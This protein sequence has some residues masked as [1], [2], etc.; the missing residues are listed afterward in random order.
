MDKKGNSKTSTLKK[1]RVGVSLTIFALLTFFFVDFAGLLSLKLHGIAH[2]QF[3]PAL[4]AFNIAIVVVILLITS[5]FG[6]IYCSSLCPMGALQDITHWISKH[7]L[8]RKRKVK[9]AKSNNI[10]RWSV[11]GVVALA[12]LLGF[13]LLLGL[14]DPYS[15]FG[16]ISTHLFKP[17]YLLGNNLLADIFNYFGN[18]T[19][20]HIEIGILAISSFIIA[21]ATLL[22][23]GFIAWRYGRL[24][25]N[26][27]CPVG[28]ILGAISKYSLFKISIDESKCNGCRLC[29]TKCKSSCIDAE[30][31]AID[32]SRCVDCFNCLGVCNQQ[33]LSFSLK[34]QPVRKE[35]QE[36][37]VDEGKRQFLLASLATA[38]AIPSAVAQKE[39]NAL[40]GKEVAGGRTA[41]SPPGSLSAEHLKKHCTSCHLCISKCPSQVLKPAFLEYGI[42]GMMQPLLSFKNGFCKYDCTVCLEV[43]PNSAICHLTV[44]EKH[45]TQIGRA[46]LKSGSCVAYTKGAHCGICAE[47]CPTQAIKMVS[48]D[49]GFSVPVI[50]TEHCIGCGACE[51]KCPLHAIYIEGCSVHQQIKH[52]L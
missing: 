28:T 40:A 4:L 11:V 37:P 52:Y 3:I 49:E 26:T 33:A 27:I 39:V 29:E 17:L 48:Y 8:N 32:H 14:L 43:C 6:R 16:R 13:P 19:L 51:Y 25:C 30:N 44:E 41:I 23:I 47:H 22:I 36:Q 15:A 42:G 12:F 7:T 18:Y 21:V 31:H 2:F 20:Y 1:I 9:Y 46:I 5:L 24:Y 38:I 10:L 45:R 34:K 35:V 50:N